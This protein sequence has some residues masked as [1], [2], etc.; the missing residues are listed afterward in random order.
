[1]SRDRGNVGPAGAQREAL[2]LVVV[3]EVHRWTASGVGRTV[4]LLAGLAGVE[5]NHTVQVLNGARPM[6]LWFAASILEVCGRR[7]TY[8]V[9]DLQRPQ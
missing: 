2:R 8:V 1:M 7:L 9:E 4:K 3:D 5:Y 6:T